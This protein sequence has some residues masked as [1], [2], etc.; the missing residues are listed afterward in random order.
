[1]CVSRQFL[2]HHKEDLYLARKSEDKEELV[3]YMQEEVLS[4]DN[5]DFINDY[6]A[7]EFEFDGTEEI[8]HIDYK[9]EDSMTYVRETYK[10]VE[11]TIRL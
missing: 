3:R 7:D 1:M 9:S 2:G 4:T 10:I 6:A 8:W 11:E 5:I